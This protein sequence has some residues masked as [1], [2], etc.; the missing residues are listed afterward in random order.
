MDQQLTNRV[1]QFALQLFDAKDELRDVKNTLKL[2]KLE[3][4]KLSKLKEYKKKLNAE[5]KEE[6]LRLETE[7]QEDPAYNKLR[8]KQLDAKEK[9]AISKQYL[10]TLLI[11]EAKQNDNVSLEVY[12]HG[13]QIKIQAQLTLKLFANGVPE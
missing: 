2:Y 4:E 6:K 5:W 11:G 3:S 1:Q 7:F 13:K 8:E 9:V 10:K 12:V